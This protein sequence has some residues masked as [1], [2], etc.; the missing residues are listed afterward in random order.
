ML[1]KYGWHQLS[2]TPTTDEA[3]ATWWLRARGRVAKA[4]M[5][6]F[7]SLVLLV[8]RGIQLHRNDRVFNRVSLSSVCLARELEQLLE[9][10]CRAGWVDRSL[11]LRE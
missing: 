7:D 5:P 8:A 1:G 4:R 11:L 3:K 6:A 9:D 2:P 10:W